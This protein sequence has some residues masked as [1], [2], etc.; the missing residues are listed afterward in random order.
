MA[1]HKPGVARYM[2][3][4]RSHSHGYDYGLAYL[5]NPT[6]LVVVAKDC[7]ATHIPRYVDHPQVA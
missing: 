1:Q 2:A 7:N 4:V 6:A 5:D 3:V